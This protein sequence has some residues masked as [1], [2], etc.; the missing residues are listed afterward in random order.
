MALIGAHTVGKA[1]PEHMGFPFRNWDNTPVV[2]CARLHRSACE[3]PPCDQPSA[4]VVVVVIFL[5]PE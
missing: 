2:S 3:D 1:H 4:L 5:E